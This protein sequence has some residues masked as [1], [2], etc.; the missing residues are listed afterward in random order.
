MMTDSWR[1]T[2]GQ[3]SSAFAAHSVAVVADQG[4]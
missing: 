3:L 4:V 2:D 1:G